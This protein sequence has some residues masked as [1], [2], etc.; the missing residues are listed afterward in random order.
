MKQQRKRS[1]DRLY[2][3]GNVYAFRYLDEAAVWREKCTG[4]CDRKSAKKFR[5][6]FVADLR[7]GALPTEMADWRLSE[8]EKW[9]LEFRRPR[10]AN[11]TQMSE[12]Y[13][14]QH[15]R[16]VLGDKRLREV[17][18]TDIDNYVTARLNGYTY[19]ADGTTSTRPGIGASSINKEVRLWSMILRKAKLWRRL[20]DDYKPLKTKAANIGKA[21]TREQLRHLAEVRKIQLGKLHFTALFSPV[22]RDCVAARSSGSRLAKSIS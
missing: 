12:Q 2:R 14:L 3:R 6:E 4:K 15:L 19:G 20:A 1:Y 18:N 22:T 17:T 11:G 16:L 21:I 7:R 8:A 9:W 5:D 13:R 10:V